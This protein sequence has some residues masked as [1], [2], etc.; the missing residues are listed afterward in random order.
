[1]AI[2]CARSRLRRS[3]LCAFVAASTALAASAVTFALSVLRHDGAARSAFV[4]AEKRVQAEQ[5]RLVMHA[6]FGVVDRS[7][8]NAFRHDR[9]AALTHLRDERRC[10]DALEL[11][12]LGATGWGAP[13]VVVRRY[14]LE[15][16]A[17]LRED[18][19]E[20]AAAAVALQMIWDVEAAQD[21]APWTTGLRMSAFA[22]ED[23][24]AALAAALDEHA[25]DPDAELA[26]RP[27]TRAMTPLDPDSLKP[28]NAGA[29]AERFA[30][31]LGATSNERIRFARIRRMHARWAREDRPLGDPIAPTEDPLASVSHVRPTD[32][33]R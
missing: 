11:R 1:M 23:M 6:R 25:V 14:R 12:A 8:A 19:L 4:L 32:A 17:P 3:T 22:A 30:L 13:F 9:A 27:L 33:G 26:G 15:S 18:E 7:H 5:G 10:G 2:V 28:E 16:T 21:A 20:D 29:R 24:V 31:P